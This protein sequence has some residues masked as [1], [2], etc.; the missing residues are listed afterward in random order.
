MI[1]KAKKIAEGLKKI[2]FI[3]NTKAIVGEVPGKL[4]FVGDQKQDYTKIRLFAYNEENFIEVILNDIS[5][6][7]YY[8]KAYKNL[9]IN[10]DGLHNISL[11]KKIGNYFNIHTLIQEDIVHTGQRAKIDIEEDHLF[12]IIKMM[13]IDLKNLQLDAEQFSMYLNEDVLLTFQEIEGDVF[14]PVRNRIRNKLGR[15][16]KKGLDYLAY[17]LLDTIV[18]KYN[19]IMEYFGYQIEELEDK[20]LLQP[21]S[22]VLHEINGY[23]IELNFFRKS[24][25]PAREAILG[26]DT[27]NIELISED[28][29]LF[30]D[31]LID[32]ITRAYESVDTYKNMLSEQLTVYSIN[33]NNKLNDI[34]KILTIFSAVFIPITFIAGIYGTNFEYIPELKYKDGYF[35]MWGA[36]IFIASSML[37]YF[38]Y[39]KW[40]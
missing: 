24:I 26:L 15:V 11:I 12:F 25:R 3:K 13:K 39:K 36:I 14:E 34:M 35:I 8:R 40:F 22:D 19:H 2:R 20:I 10:I 1:K 27:P 38:K 37:G 32:S 28:I 9:W 21:N 23:K 16:R 31:D 18:D 33:V 6:V 5:E 17:C 4:V 29:E 30:Y 7:E